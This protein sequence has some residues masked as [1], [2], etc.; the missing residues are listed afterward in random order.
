[1]TFLQKVVLHLL[2]KNHIFASF[3]TTFETREFHS[4]IINTTETTA[5]TE[6]LEHHQH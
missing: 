6:S 4:Q 3:N 5:A 1:M 2:I